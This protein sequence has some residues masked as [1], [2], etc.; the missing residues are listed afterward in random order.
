L[1]AR[2]SL[3]NRYEGSTEE[4]LIGNSAEFENDTRLTREPVKRCQKWDRIGN[5]GYRVTT[6]AKQF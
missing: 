5:R 1:G 2:E 6:L 4:Y 3:E